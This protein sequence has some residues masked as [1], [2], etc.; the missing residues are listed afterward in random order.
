MDPTI[1][2]SAS[3][4]RIQ[5]LL[6]AATFFTFAYFHQGGGWNQNARF[7]MVRAIVEEGTLRIDSYLVYAGVGSGPE[8]RLVR[9][10]VRNAG[11]TF[12]GRE[13]AFGWRDARGQNVPL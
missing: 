7:A 4:R 10:P 11:F 9:V 1:T 6:F 12:E 13:Y 3:G 5:W 8:S 2:T